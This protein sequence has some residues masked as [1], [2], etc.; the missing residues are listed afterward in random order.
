MSPT[1]RKVDLIINNHKH[2]QRVFFFEAFKDRVEVE[3]CLKFF[4]F[5]P[6]M[7][8]LVSVVFRYY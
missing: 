7:F 6:K 3:R 1:L 4:T 8:G 5:R 2:R